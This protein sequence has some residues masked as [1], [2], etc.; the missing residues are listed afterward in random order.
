MAEIALFLR[1]S[2][3]AVD[4]YQSQIIVILVSVSKSEIYG[5]TLLM[6]LKPKIV[7]LA[8]VGVGVAA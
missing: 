2:R 5:R 3:I 6:I 7:L 1:S 8:A 4:T